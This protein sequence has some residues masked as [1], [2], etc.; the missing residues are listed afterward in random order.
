MA[1]L[2]A[3][4]TNDFAKITR[5]AYD[6]AFQISPIFLVGG[7]VNGIPGGVLPIILLPG[8]IIGEAQGAL[9]NLSLGSGDAFAEFL[10]IPGSTI[11]N[12]TVGMYPFA[13]QQVAA[14]ATIQQPLAISLRMIAP[15]KDTAGYLTKLAIYESISTVLTNHNNAG[16]AYTV[17]TPAHVYTNCL[18]LTITDI[19]NNDSKQQQI[20][21]QWDFIKPTITASDAAAAMNGLMNK[22]TSGGKVVSPS[23]SQGFSN[24]G[25]GSI[26]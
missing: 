15:V 12:Q 3:A 9:S 10:P 16:G 22:L 25:T 23:W 14:N 19:T 26:P 1:I 20:E 6:L 18:L 24:I 21:W 11:V 2:S 17:L 4:Q 7:I 8:F 5:T 13:N